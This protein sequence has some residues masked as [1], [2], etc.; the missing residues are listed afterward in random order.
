MCLVRPETV[1]LLPV[2]LAVQL[3]DRSR[4]WRQVLTQMGS[5]TLVVIACLAMYWLWRWHYYGEWLPNTYYAKAGGP[6]GPHLFWGLA[7]SVQLAQTWLV[8]ITLIVW[9]ARQREK[10]SNA[11]AA[12]LGLYI[13]YTVWAGG[14][15][16]PWLRFYWPLLPVATI[17][18]VDTAACL[19]GPMQRYCGKVQTG[20]IIPAVFVAYVILGSTRT[21]GAPGDLRTLVRQWTTVG[22]WAQHNLD[23]H[24]RIALGPIGAIG[25]FSRQPV[26]DVLGLTDY[27]TAHFGQFDPSEAPGHQKSDLAS[28]LERSPEIVL[29]QAMLFAKP[30]TPRQASQCATRHALQKLYALPQFQEMYRYETVSIDGQYLPLW[31]R[32]DLPALG[33]VAMGPN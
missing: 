8:P 5:V 29:G 6:L 22:R 17:L 19:W 31:V 1:M 10:H 28:L 21:I 2:A 4:P 13:V 7:Y 32:R 33:T 24:Y 26:I 12:S 14:D 9:L 3:V 30:L 20:L 16:F 11:L 27:H 15:H 18:L 25:W 23:P